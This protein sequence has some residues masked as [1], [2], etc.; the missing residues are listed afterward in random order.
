MVKSAIYNMLQIDF[1][2]QHFSY[3]SLQILKPLNTLTFRG[4]NSA[5]WAPC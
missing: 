4:F 3:F 1:S 5:N 2:L